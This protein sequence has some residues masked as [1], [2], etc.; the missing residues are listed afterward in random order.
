M[1][2]A[3]LAKCT[4]DFNIAIRKIS[5]DLAKKGGELVLSDLFRSY[6][7]QYQAYLDYKTGKKKAY[8]PPPGGSMHEAGRAMD[9]DL[10][11][12]KVTLKDFW[13]IATKYG[14]CP[15]INKPDTKLSEAWHFDCRGSHAVVYEYYKSGKGNN[16]APYTAMAVSAILA[17]GIQVDRFA[18][19][20]K[21]AF[22]QSG[23][24]RLGY[25]IGN[26]DGNIGKR[27][28]AALKSIGI[29]AGSIDET[30]KLVE[31]KLQVKF[32]SEFTI[33]P[34]NHSD[35]DKPGHVVG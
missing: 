23:L 9:I 6:D 25:D 11:K 10:S 24:I 20:S 27:T 29:S 22:I 16:M 32:P 17:T 28:N 2:P 35:D 31:D 18:G 15:I 12:I 14:C 34:E 33:P 4:P 30:M 19:K 26:I 3:R 5:E 1:L 13:N 8:S 21:E 7:M